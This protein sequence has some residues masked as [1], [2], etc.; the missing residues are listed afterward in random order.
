MRGSEEE[1]VEVGEKEKIRPAAPSA[2][3]PPYIFGASTLQAMNSEKARRARAP[4]KSL[5]ATRAEAERAV[6]SLR[7]ARRNAR[8][9]TR[10]EA[11]ARR[12]CARDAAP[13]TVASARAT[14]RARL[15]SIDGRQTS[16]PGTAV[17]GR[18]YTPVC[19]RA[20]YPGVHLRATRFL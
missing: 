11:H 19:R 18:R 4:R 12:I 9:C 20:L 6:R 5:I 8:K 16:S 17:K 14:V 2:N 13:S 7:S 10:V 1:R 3:P 15:G